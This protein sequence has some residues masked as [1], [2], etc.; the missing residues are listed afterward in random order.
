LPIEQK[1]GFKASKYVRR[2][3]ERRAADEKH[4]Q[5]GQAD[6]DLRTKVVLS[7]R[8]P[9]TAIPPL[10]PGQVMDS[11]SW[12]EFIKDSK[13]TM[14]T[15]SSQS[16]AL[17]A[18][19]QQNSLKG[20]AI[21]DDLQREA[22]ALDAAVTEEEVKVTDRYSTVHFNS[23][24][25][26]QDAPLA[27][28]EPQ[29]LIDYKTGLPFLSDNMSSMLSN[30]GVTLPVR[31]DAS[32]P[33]VDVALVGEGTDVGDTRWPI[34]ST[35]PNNLLR[36]DRVFRHVV[37][38]TD[39]DDTSRKYNYTPSYCT[40]QLELSS[41]Q[42]INR[43]TVRPV[44][45]SAVYVDNISYLNESGE[46]VDLSQLE[47]GSETELTVLFEPIRTR[48]LNVRFRQYAPV[49][50]AAYDTGDLRTREINKL[51]RGAGFSQL[52][53]ENSERIQGRVYD[54]SLQSVAVGLRAYENLGVFRSQPVSAR[55]PLGV[56]YSDV[57]ETIQVTSDS[58][59]Y[60]E[61]YFL[62][63]GEVLLE[64][65]LGLDLVGPNKEQSLHELVPIPDGVTVQREFLPIFNGEAKCKLFPDLQWNIDKLLVSDITWAS[66][67]ASIEFQEP[68]ELGAVSPSIITDKLVVVGGP[69]EELGQ[70][71][72]STIEW[73]VLSE[74][75][76]VAKP[77]EFTGPASLS[78]PG[79]KILPYVFVDA[80]R[81]V[82]LTAYKGASQLTLGTD[83][84]ISLD[85]GSTWLTS[86]PSGR[87]WL[88][89]E[90]RARAGQFK[91]RFLAADPDG[92]YWINYR[93]A[94]NQQL[95]RKPGVLLRNSRVVFDR[96]FLDSSGTITT[97]IVSRADSV[98]PYLTPVLLSYLLRVRENVS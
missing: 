22:A 30:T 65:Y 27:A 16:G 42:L 11:V 58:K 12:V 15:I 88:A 60:G 49:T 21:L 95:S 26:A 10:A 62:N 67:W 3:A 7:Q 97:V 55:A 78:F 51:L 76:I 56:A 82:P 90:S 66:G 2:A 19:I 73:Y 37:I 53:D 74:T 39:H 14:G 96:R 83:Y 29:W 77:A 79:S 31:F 47:L 38:R 94:R 64:R 68:H 6:L 41:L 13:M 48:Y 24:V 33:I 28:S 92:L 63:E 89:I 5:V 46:E 8:G 1:D 69:G 86:W 59:T 81:A 54:F 98:N 4:V 20:F 57:V 80:T 34:V 61:S 36:D 72:F 9:S 25:R 45:H 17:G 84:E 85:S 43:L 75:I 32:T 44:G 40:L 52:L 50:R 23:F 18:E 87:A 91:I 71:N 93:Y 70:F 35:N